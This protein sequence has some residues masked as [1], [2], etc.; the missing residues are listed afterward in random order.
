MLED[1][2]NTIRKDNI[3]SMDFLKSEEELVTVNEF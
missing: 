3:K 2:I 1:L